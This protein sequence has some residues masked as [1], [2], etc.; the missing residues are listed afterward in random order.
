MAEILL[1]KRLEAGLWPPP[2]SFIVCLSKRRSRP[3]SQQ[4]RPG[5]CCDYFGKIGPSSGSRRACARHHATL[6]TSDSSRKA[7][8]AFFFIFLS[9]FLFYNIYLFINYYV[10]YYVKNA[11]SPL[12]R[13]PDIF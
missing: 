8:L 11:I 13:K 12:Q 6:T 4:P 3:S 10:E 5:Q 9:F 2:D 7:L 1:E